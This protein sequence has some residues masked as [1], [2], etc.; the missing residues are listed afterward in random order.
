VSAGAG[1]KLDFN[2][3]L[4]TGE[5][6]KLQEAVERA[7]QQLVNNPE[8][9]RAHPVPEIMFEAIAKL[10]EKEVRE[11]FVGALAEVYRGLVK[12]TT[13]TD[14]VEAHRAA[15]AAHAR[16]VE[17]KAKE[18]T[19]RQ[20]AV[21]PGELIAGLEKFFLERAYLP[22]GGALLLAYFAINTWTFELFD[23][24]PYISLESATPGC[25][26][27]TMLR[28][29]KAVCRRSRATTALT[30]AVLF[31]LI[32]TEQPTLLIDEAETIEGRSDRAEALKAIAHEGYKLGGLV[33]RCEGDEHAIRWFDV[34]CP[35]A[36]AAIGGLTGALL[37]R[38][39][40]LHMEKAPKGNS[41][42]STRAR[43]LER[44][45]KPLRAMLE[46]YAVQ[47]TEKLK[48]LYEAEP[49]AGYW[50]AITDREAELWSPL[51]Y[52]ARLAGPEL[53]AQLLQV[54]EIFAEE[55]VDIQAAEWR[56]AQTIALLAAIT[57]HDGEEFTPSDLLDALG[58]DESWA[59]PFAEVKGTGDEA[60]AAKAAK[61][62]YTLRKFRLKS[63]KSQG[64]MRYSKEEAIR[65]LSAHV[66]ENP[67]HSPQSPSGDPLP[68]Q[69]DE[70]KATGEG[71]ETREGFSGACP[72]NSDGS[73]KA[74]SNLACPGCGSRSDWTTD[75]GLAKHMA[76]CRKVKQ[77]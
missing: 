17:D 37:E 72:D 67:P 21:N 59:K 9:A 24:T 11:F 54:V 71:A 41:R 66:P 64:R 73:A 25:G 8:A 7:I 14:R 20:M 75:I 26:K 5:V 32:D 60:K 56:V 52:H 49:D 43:A 68:K 40:V 44:D 23:T 58:E 31:R 4:F 45:A 46:A 51:L 62:G 74:S 77:V 3:S 53:E 33:P 42:K 65:V 22:K 35:K 16:R 47:T 39:H 27:S 2:D 12:K 38:C 18:D 36:F 13:L 19:F 57:Q 30:E 15:A 48:R 10:P 50:P 34:Y 55:K 28:L 61:V 29:L 76:S 6:K 1:V 69:H 63:R 70:N